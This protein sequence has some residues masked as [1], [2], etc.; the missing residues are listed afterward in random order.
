[1]RSVKRI[2]A[3]Y[4]IS[5]FL[6]DL[7]L[8]SLALAFLPKAILFVSNLHFMGILIL[9]QN[10]TK[11]SSM[12]KALLF[13]LVME[14]IHVGTFPVFIISYTLS[15]VVIRQW[16]RYLGFTVLEFLIMVVIA[17]FIKE[18]IGYGLA[19]VL[20]NYAVS[21]FNF[22]ATRL[23]WTIIGNVCIL[24]IVFKGYKI[25]HAAIMKRAEN[26]YMK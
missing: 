26:L 4:L 9:S 20:N 12:L 11:E 1:M 6:I 3:L 21:F 17:L 22:G 24:P 15:V 23:V 18:V 7:I 13:G 25:T 16:E 2:H 19:V 8:S 5:L 10:E 14:L